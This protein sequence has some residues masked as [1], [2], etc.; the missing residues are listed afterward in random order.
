MSAHVS[1]TD[2]A[3]EQSRA[4]QIFFEFELGSSSRRV[5]G[6]CEEAAVSWS[7]AP[8]DAL[9]LHHQHRNDGRNRCC[10]RKNVCGHDSISGTRAAPTL[11]VIMIMHSS[12]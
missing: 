6:F 10:E 2:P 7:E 8:M 1:M 4:P 5:R 12:G 9:K 3:Q 11:S